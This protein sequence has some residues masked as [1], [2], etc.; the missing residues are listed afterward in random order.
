MGSPCV[1]YHTEKYGSAGLSIQPQIQCVERKGN[2]H[3]EKQKQT[4]ALPKIADN[5]GSKDVVILSQGRGTGCPWYAE[6]ERNKHTGE[7]VLPKV[8]KVMFHSK[9]KKINLDE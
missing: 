6:E 1:I 4:K 2:L 3:G 5:R 7:T 8:F 9:M